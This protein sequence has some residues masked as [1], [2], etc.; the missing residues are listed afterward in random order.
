METLT[1]GLKAEITTTAPCCISLQI[2]VPAD[3]V[4]KTYSSILGQYSQKVARPGFRAGHTPRQLILSLYGKAIEDETTERLVN[5]SLNEVVSEKKLRVAGEFSLEG[6]KTPPYQAGQEYAFR[7]S[8]EV[9][10]DFE[11]RPNGPPPNQ[12]PATDL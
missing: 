10:A 1:N 12:F 3:T 2:V 11:T 5:Q 9:Y 6:G 7:V 8:T 4:K